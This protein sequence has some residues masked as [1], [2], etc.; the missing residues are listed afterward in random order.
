MQS[1]SHTLIFWGQ[2]IADG[3][4]RT[5]IQATAGPL[6]KNRKPASRSTHL[7]AYRGEKLGFL[8]CI[9]VWVVPSVNITADDGTGR[10]HYGGEKASH[11]QLPPASEQHLGVVISN[12]DLLFG[13]IEIT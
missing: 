5:H 4:L 8:L 2:E 6:Y 1:W 9:M 13:A 10:I 12:Y 7:T 3:S 11:T